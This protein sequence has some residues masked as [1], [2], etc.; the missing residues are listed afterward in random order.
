M[1]SLFAFSMY[2]RRK[3]INSGDV[4]DA[5]LKQRNVVILQL[6]NVVFMV[7]HGGI[8]KVNSFY[9]NRLSTKMFGG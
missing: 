3:L 8:S 2:Y 1:P 9:F 7:R 5:R 4:C 6:L